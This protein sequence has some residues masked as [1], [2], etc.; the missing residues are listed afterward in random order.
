MEQDALL[1][2]VPFP[3]AHVLRK[4]A[5]QPKAECAVVV[6]RPRV[7]VPKRS[8]YRLNPTMSRVAIAH[9]EVPVGNALEGLEGLLHEVGAEVVQRIL[10][11][12]N[13]ERPAHIIRPELI[14]HKARAALKTQIAGSCGLSLSA[15]SKLSIA[16]SH[17]P[18]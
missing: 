5:L 4:E 3:R 1:T 12:D 14:S 10:R 16:L 15:R 2:L 6:P 11:E 7:G 18:K 8:S 13:V 9:Q 17:R